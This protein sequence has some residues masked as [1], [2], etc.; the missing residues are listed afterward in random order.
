MG[1]AGNLSGGLFL[2]T[3]ET[4]VETKPCSGLGKFVAAAAV[5]H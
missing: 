5:G 3:F 4:A 1:A 2:A